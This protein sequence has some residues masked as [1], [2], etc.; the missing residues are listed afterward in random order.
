MNDGL[1]NDLK[2][3]IVTDINSTMRNGHANGISVLNPID[4]SACLMMTL[5][6]TS[7]R[8][9]NIDL[10]ACSDQIKYLQLNEKDDPDLNTIENMYQEVC[11]FVFIRFLTLKR[12]KLLSKTRKT[13]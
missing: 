2:I 11:I 5:L 1:I 3:A 6:Y 7:K 13:R 8:R 9:T 10:F 4:I 12:I